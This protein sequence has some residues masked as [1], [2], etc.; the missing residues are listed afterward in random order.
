MGKTAFILSMARAMAVDYGTAVGI[1]SLEMSKAQ[2]M[3]RLVV[4]HS[5]IAN[6]DK[7]R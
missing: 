3:T 4:N 5:G 7:E 1:F 2:L 6:E